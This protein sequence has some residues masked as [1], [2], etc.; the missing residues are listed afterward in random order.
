MTDLRKRFGLAP[1]DVDEQQALQQLFPARPGVD[2]HAALDTTGGELVRGLRSGYYGAVQAAPRALVAAAQDAAGYKDAATQSYANVQNLLRR[3][4]NAKPET[5]WKDVN[6]PLSFGRYA[7]GAVGNALSSFAPGVAVGLA[8]RSP[9]LG[10]ATVF[11]ME[12][13]ETA[14]EVAGLPADQR[15]DAGKTLRTSLGKGAVN[16]AIEAAPF[17]HMFGKGPLRALTAGV[18]N[19]AAR[20]GGRVATQMGAEG[21]TEYLQE[22]VGQVAK[23]EL[24]PGRDKSQDAEQRAEAFRQGV[25]GA[26]PFAG[27]AGVSGAVQD[28]KALARSGVDKAIDFLERSKDKAAADILADLRGG[29]RMQRF[30]MFING[31][32]TAEEDVL[33]QG[34]NSQLSRSI[35]NRK[36]LDI[37]ERELGAEIDK[38]LRAEGPY[39]KPEYAI[40]FYQ[41]LHDLLGDNTDSVIEHYAKGIDDTNSLTQRHE[42]I[43]VEANKPPAWLDSDGVTSFSEAD[44]E[45]SGDDLKQYVAEEHGLQSMFKGDS[46]YIYDGTLTSRRPFSNKAAGRAAVERVKRMNPHVTN[47]EYIPVL[48]AVYESGLDPEDVRRELI[49][50]TRESLQND[51]N[52]GNKL[53][54][55]RDTVGV[56]RVRKRIRDGNDI[57]KKLGNEVVDPETGEIKFNR[58][59]VEALSDLY[60]VRTNGSGDDQKFS[61]KDIKEMKPGSDD[62]PST[63]QFVTDGGK[64]VNIN[65]REMMRKHMKRADKLDDNG[66]IV[67]PRVWMYRA[68]MSGL[69]GLQNSGLRLKSELSDDLLVSADRNGEN[70]ITLGDLKKAEQAMATRDRRVTNKG[71]ELP[72]EQAAREYR[73]EQARIAN[74]D[75]GNMVTMHEGPEGTAGESFDPTANTLRDQQPGGPPQYTDQGEEIWGDTQEANIR[76]FNE[77][78]VGDSRV[79][80]VGEVW[81]TGE[82]TPQFEGR[83]AKPEKQGAGEIG[84][85]IDQLIHEARLKDEDKKPL[86]MERKDIMAHAKRAAERGAKERPDLANEQTVAESK[87][88]L[89]AS[90]PSELVDDAPPATEVPENYDAM[91]EPQVQGEAAPP[92]ML[93]RVRNS[94]KL[95]ATEFKAL[96]EEVRA[97]LKEGKLPLEER[98]VLAKALG[99]ASVA[100]TRTVGLEQVN[101]DELDGKKLL[102]ARRD[103]MFNEALNSTPEEMERRV[104]ATI[105]EAVSLGLQKGVVAA[106]ENSLSAVFNPTQTRLIARLLDDLSRY[107][108]ISKNPDAEKWVRNNLDS[109]TDAITA[110]DALLPLVDD[111]F[112]KSVLVALRLTVPKGTTI[113]KADLTANNQLG[114][115]APGEGVIRLEKTKPMLK[116]LIHEL[117]HAATLNAVAK[118]P[119]AFEALHT[120]F[121]HVRTSNK[122]FDEMYGATNVYEFLAE[123]LSNANLRQ[124]LRNTPA[125]VEVKSLL[126]KVKNLW[127]GFVRVIR[128]SLGMKPEDENALSQF[129]DVAGAL[130]KQTYEQ[131][132]RG[133][134]QWAKKGMLLTSPVIRKDFAEKLRKLPDHMRKGVEI[135]LDGRAPAQIDLLAVQTFTASG[136]RD[137]SEAASSFEAE[138]YLIAQNIHFTDL[139]DSEVSLSRSVE[140]TGTDLTAEEQQKIKDLIKQ[141]RGPDVAVSFLKALQIGP[142][143]MNEFGRPEHRI[144]A[145]G[146]FLKENDSGKRIIDLAVDVSFATAESAAYHE[147]MHDFLASLRGKD[148]TPEMRAA[149]ATIENMHKNVEVMM[150]L[151]KLLKDHPDAWKAAQDDPNEAAAYIYQFWVK[152]HITVGPAPRNL[153]E[154]LVKFFR[155]ALNIVGSDDKARILMD[156]LAKGSFAKPSIAADVLNSLKAETFRDKTMRIAGPLMKVTSVVVSSTTDRLREMNIPAFTEIA[157]LFHK[158]ADQERGRLGYLQKSGQM[159]A[160]WRARLN[161]VLSDH[162]QDDLKKALKLLQSR[163]DSDMPLV[164]GIRSLLNDMYDYMSKAGVKEAERRREKVWDENLKQEVEKEVTHWVPIKKVAYNY[165]PRFWDQTAIQRDQAK[166]IN[167]LMKHGKISEAEAGGIVRAI[168]SSP[169]NEIVDETTYT[170]YM[171]SANNRRLHFINETN[172]GEFAEFQKQDLVEIMTNYV[173]HAVHRAES[174]R[175]FGH[176]YERIDKLIERGR[177]EGATEDDVKVAQ[178]AVAAMTGSLR[179]NMDRGIRQFMTNMIAYENV[180]LLPFAL[181]NNLTDVVHVALRSGDL[182]EGWRAFGTGIAEMKNAIMRQ[183]PSEQRRFAEA[184]GTIDET[185]AL[186]AYGE[187]YEGMYMTGFARKLNNAF[188]KYNGMQTWNHAMRIAATQAGVRFILRHATGEKT[189]HSDRYLYELGL[190]REFVSK[191][192]DAD[193]NLAVFRDDIAKALGVDRNSGEAAVAETKIQE[194]LYRFADDAALRPNAAHRPIWGSDPYYMLLFHLKQFTYTFQ[195]VTA[196]F[197]NKEMAYGSAM[198]VAILLAY[199]PF[200]LAIQT[201]RSLMLGHP[202]DTSFGGVMM[203]LAKSGTM[204]GTGTFGLDA[205]K[206]TAVGRVPGISL[207]GPAPAHGLAALQTLLGADGTSLAKLAERSVPLSPLVKAIL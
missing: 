106:S 23:T 53:Q 192:I 84:T 85:P 94:G 177:L 64:L 185:V 178:R 71:I 28:T 190:D 24:F 164:K 146:R 70:R 18:T 154:K 25:L 169:Q 91:P 195:A 135:V 166:F 78:I 168:T 80:R 181:L 44:L 152:G 12:A 66:S 67:P 158:E 127:E 187:A 86:S 125:N 30:S 57:L 56:E 40:R 97:V 93:S 179:H 113:E 184:L 87:R 198:P 137:V 59:I 16:T 201:V 73:D 31:N 95:S 116:T 17:A 69:A 162:S 141:Q 88:A 149:A 163:Q 199:A 68:L 37:T 145:A 174:T 60:V 96:T 32:P 139:P 21:G 41:E 9:A 194:A 3:A 133:D 20:F 13:G 34:E 197:M 110:I 83:F 4:A 14:S 72:E 119:N 122:F 160:Q 61:P 108:E 202:I 124:L 109:S 173:S 36:K 10:L 75:I 189:E 196:K 107:A 82:P 126:G 99:E 5:Q 92:S 33:K 143:E 183:P 132:L 117:V 43:R 114:S 182:S 51:V 150:Q 100:R 191:L 180:V 170:P 26:L 27:M 76:K 47:A 102:N 22:A 123:G 140:T 55:K 142:E 206:D 147:S 49:K 153:F 172:A 129:L 136:A 8:T 120:L 6:D 2:P 48:Q 115:Y 204:L 144:K 157:D 81:P 134:P 130:M 50:A 111:Q 105:R 155:D 176:A 58:S 52:E 193:G 205:L 200:A 151:K 19:P 175:A 159:G 35:R 148:S 74:S 65:V 171:M 131:D 15:P 54:D 104:R 90:Q 156:A 118:N 1:T 62:A 138:R 45:L 112:T 7:A 186:G 121:D 63:I 29:D 167:L 39:A 203:S 161:R 38:Y 207:I 77:N 89:L 46:D 101:E 165:F 128:Q 103:A 79:A 11:P 42:E 188:F 98:K